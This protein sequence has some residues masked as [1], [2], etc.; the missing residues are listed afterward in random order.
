MI[1]YKIPINK[2]L[3]FT[4]LIL[5]YL[6]FNKIIKMNMIR[7]LGLFNQGMREVVE[8]FYLNEEPVVLDGR[9]YEVHF[10]PVP[11]TSYKEGIAQTLEFMSS[12]R[13]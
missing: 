11:R 3:F 5:N 7:F 9:K 10:G 2:L 4:G 8:M 6:L 13:T 12:R 1:I